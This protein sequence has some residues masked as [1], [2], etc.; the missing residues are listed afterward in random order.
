MNPA[1]HLVYGLGVS[2]DAPPPGPGEVQVTDTPD[3]ERGIRFELQRMREAVRASVS[4]EIGG[5]FVS[6]VRDVLTSVAHLESYGHADPRY[7]RAQ[8][9]AWFE[10]FKANFQYLNDPISISCSG[11]RC[12]T[13]VKE[14]IQTPQRMARYIRNAH[15]MISEI[16]R[17]LRGREL[18]IGGGATYKVPQNVLVKIT[19]DCDEAAIGTAAGPAA[20]GIETAFRL[21]G[22]MDRETGKPEFHHVWAVGLIEGA[23]NP[24]SGDEWWDMDATLKN[25]NLGQFAPFD[26]Y[27]KVFIFR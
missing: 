4:D 19:G 12:Q 23:T 7:R 20:V 22:H 14:V 27:A 6:V 9:A 5:E 15:D 17:P 11:G 10:W 13:T 1:F 26:V 25:F 16:T 8:M 2:P 24:M 18:H 21:G 3:D